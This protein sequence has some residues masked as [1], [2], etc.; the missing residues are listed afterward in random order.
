MSQTLGITNYT[1]S[2]EVYLKYSSTS[3]GQNTNKSLHNLW[4]NG[5]VVKVQV[6]QTKDTRFKTIRC[7]KNCLSFHTSKVNLWISR[8]PGN[9]VVKSKSS[10]WLYCLQQMN[11]IHKVFHRDKWTLKRGHD[12]FL[13]ST[14]LKYIWS[15]HKV[16]WKYTDSIY[17]STK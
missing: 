14:L 17:T 13:Y 11:Y 8:I 1:W 2:T 15:I 12:F 4:S 9:L 3:A 5:L 10:K 16:Y 6:Y 7:L